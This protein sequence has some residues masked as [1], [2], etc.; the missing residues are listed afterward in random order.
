MKN[1]HPDPYKHKVISF[2]KSATR[3][4]GYVLIPFNIV[5]AV[6]VLFISEVIGIVEELV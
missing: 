5:A 4:T 1:N 6:V 2:I 3:L